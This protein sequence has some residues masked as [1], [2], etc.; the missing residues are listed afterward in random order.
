MVLRYRGREERV[1]LPDEE[2]FATALL[3]L[4]NPREITI[5]A[6][7]GHGEAETGS[8]KDRG[9]SRFGEL[10]KDRNLVIQEVLLAVQGIPPVCRVVFVPGPQK[11]FNPAELELL[12]KFYVQGGGILFLMDPMDK[13][14]GNTFE[15]FMKSFGIRISANVIVDKMSKTVGGDFLVPFVNQYNLQHP[16]TQDFHDPTFFPIARTV[17]PVDENSREVVPVA[18]SG[19]SSWA[20]TNLKLL[21][22]GEAVF[23]IETDTP[24]PLSIAV[25]VTPQAGS[26][27]S[28]NNSKPKGRMVVIGDSDF[29]TNA[30]LDLSANRVFAQRALDWTANDERVMHLAPKE[31]VLADFSMTHSQRF[32]FLISFVAGM[33]LLFF[34]AGSAEI[35]WRSCRS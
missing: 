23:E 21:E 32:V 26:V 16:I 15:N 12:R 14:T 4:K 11:N 31:S 17:E 9:L 6:V 13:A 22:Q 29:I 34:A 18:F 2:F 3:R 20:E 28:A 33:P 10:L 24:G 27:K 25:A 8:D 30:Y 35:I 19:S 1:V 5:C 7:T